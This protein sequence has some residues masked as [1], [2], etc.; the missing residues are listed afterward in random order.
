MRIGTFHQT[1]F[2]TKDNRV[3]CHICVLDWDGCNPYFLSA[4]VN[5]KQ[6]LE[7]TPNWDAEMDFYLP[8]VEEE[9][10]LILELFPFQDNGVEKRCRYLPPKPWSVDF[11]L[12]S[13]EDLGYCA[14]ANTL[15]SECADY[16]DAAVELAERDPGYDYVIEHYWW[17]RGYEEYRD[18]EA[19]ERLKR[20]MQQGRIELSAPHC[21]NHTHWQ[22]GE[23]LVRAL[24]YACKEGKET[25]GITPRTVVYADIAGASWS[26][27]SAYA[28]AGIRYLCLLANRYLRFSKDDERLPRLFWWQ[29]PNVK[30]RLLCFLQEGYKKFSISHAMGAAASQTQ[31]GTYFFDQSRMDATVGAVDALIEE[32]ADAPYDKI[33]V[34]FYMDRE[35]PN[36]DMKTV[37]DRM[38]E[39]WK[40]PKLG[41]STP[42]KILSYIEER[43]GD[44]LPVL[45]GDITDQWADFAAI[46]PEWFSAKRR[47][48][49]LFP[50]S[51]TFA[52]LNAWRRG[53]GKWPGIRLDEALWK[54]C[55]FDDH[56]WATSS[57]HPQEMHKFNLN[58]VKK[59]NAKIALGLIEGILTEAIGLPGE[60]E[61]SVWNPLPFALHAP[62]RL[63]EGTV[64][65]GMKTQRL[66]DGS[67]LT[68]AAELPSC[69]YRNFPRLSERD[70]KE[71]DRTDEELIETPFYRICVNRDRK[72][73]ES[74][75]EKTTG[76]E[77]LDQDSEFS[78]GE[79][80]YVHAE[81]K[82]RPPVTM[83]F[84]SRRSL[85]VFCGPLAVEIVTEAFEEQIGANIRS[86]FTFYR[87]EKTIDVHL[88]FAN[89]TGLM[90]DFYDRYKKNLFFA[91]PF[92]VQYPYF[93]TELA[94]GIVDERRDRMPINPHD[95]VM[96]HSWVSVENGQ[97][98]IGLFSRDMPLF[99]LG[100]IH[101][102]EI[103]SRVDYGGSSAIFLYAASNRS[104]NLN[105]VTPADCHGEFRLSI[106]PF[107]GTSDHV[108]PRW[109]YERLCS[110]LVG[111][112]QEGT[113]RSF[114]SLDGPGMRLLCMKPDR[115]Q[116]GIFLRLYETQGRRVR[117][118]LTLP[119]EAEDVR[120][121][122]NLEQ[123]VGERLVWQG[124][125]ISFTADPF[126]YVNLLIKPSWEW[127]LVPERDGEWLEMVSGPSYEEGN[128]DTA[129]GLRGCKNVFSFPVENTGTVVCFEKYGAHAARYAVLEGD[130]EILRGEDEP[131][132]IQKCT[133]PGTGYG[134]LR[135]AAVE[136][137][138]LKL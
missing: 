84:P 36:M 105:Y 82:D 62:L 22:G 107:E 26:C 102:N 25:W 131:Y 1:A 56:C 70:A 123:P 61:M 78:L 9:S 134:E 137:G 17:L 74:I 45:S 54:M 66:E 98:G 35:Y 18:D 79:C 130:R 94:G 59:Q 38:N 73:I 138:S 34:S 39:V 65:A 126:S 91:F 43:F 75:L 103:S 116:E 86:I 121:A 20:L 40:Y 113:Q 58:L 80:V 135:V 85:T 117:G 88:S 37:C 51:E 99:H 3:K 76:R 93:C 71:G 104:N 6:V 46:S 133:L 42:E 92:L 4:T 108:L 72:K 21:S 11:F 96:A 97:F 13:H 69:G 55:E 115:R 124:R 57:K 47:A 8:A 19:K 52:L 63:P 77:L 14:Y 95:F 101:Y 136:E 81:C 12:S 68:E 31:G 32:F 110:P 64:P 7:R 112:G 29:A 49:S 90:G 60:R 30:D 83:E 48:Q 10:V 106:L 132:R 23:Q 28:N 114:L 128:A 50:V 33:P 118:S 125:K 122:D 111:A 15:A 27:V 2:V 109:S 67:V 24:Y 53:G 41:I 5:D 44:D 119:F 87:E 127:K 120:L 89:A 16:L 100:G 129:C